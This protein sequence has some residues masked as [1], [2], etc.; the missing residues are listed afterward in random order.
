MSSAIV[1]GLLMVSRALQLT[2]WFI[3]VVLLSPYTWFYS[4]HLWDISFL[5]PGTALAF[6]A[7]VLFLQNKNAWA[8]RAA[9]AFSLVLPMIHFIA[10][11]ISGA[12]LGHMLLFR[13]R[14]AWK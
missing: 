7:Y 8:L 13:R 3:P 1:V 14:D 6:G 2:K 12:I 9:V 4:R 5:M 10:L 11:P